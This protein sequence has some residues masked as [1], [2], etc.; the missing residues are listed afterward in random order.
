MQDGKNDNSTA[1][2]VAAG[3][4][5]SKSGDAKDDTCSENSST[6]I[7][8]FPMRLLATEA[9]MFYAMRFMLGSLS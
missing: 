5:K 7:L 2:K 9:Y 4:W 1:K 6:A 8:L 3:K